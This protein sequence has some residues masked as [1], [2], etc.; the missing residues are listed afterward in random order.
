M[1]PKEFPQESEH[2]PPKSL[3]RDRYNVEMSPMQTICYWLCEDPRGPDLTHQ[4]AADELGIDRQQVTK[5]VKR[6]RE[7]F[8]DPDKYWAAWG[9]EMKKN[10][11]EEQE[12]ER[13]KPAIDSLREQFDLSGKTD[14]QIL[15]S[16]QQLVSAHETLLGRELTV[17]EIEEIWGDD[18]P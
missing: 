5:H 1:D 8:P 12:V 6:A 4:E 16:A 10:I 14:F 13:L 17:E 15:P 2:S 18:E 11:R 9:E 7:H 3:L